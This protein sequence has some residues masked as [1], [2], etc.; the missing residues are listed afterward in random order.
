MKRIPA[1]L[2]LLLGALFTLITQGCRTTEE[3]YRKAYEAA[4]SQ[5]QEA[6]AVDSTVYGRARADVPTSTLTA[7]G[8]SMPVRREYV[9]YTEGGGSSRDNVKRYCIVAGQFRQMFNA[10]QMRQRLIDNGYAGAMVVHTRDQLYYVVAATVDT[11]DEAAAQWRRITGDKQI[12]LRA[13]MPFILMP[14]HI[15]TVK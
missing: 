11:P 13:P 1:S 7:D 14:A 5:R 2:T 3:N 12:V 10:K 6:A 9:G 4:V 15:N 8:L